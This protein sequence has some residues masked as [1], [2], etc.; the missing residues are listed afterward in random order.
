MNNLAI[1]MITWNG[2]DLIEKALQAVLP[3]VQ[4]AVVCD[5]GSTDNTINILGELK[6]EFPCLN[7]Y[8]NSIQHLGEVWSDSPIDAAI[9]DILNEMKNITKSKWILRVDDDEIFPED[10]MKEIID[11]EPTELAYA[12]SFIHFEG[13]HIIDP[14][15]HKIMLATR[16]FKNIPEIRWNGVFG[17]EALAY[18]GKRYSAKKCKILNNPFLHFGEFRKPERQHTSPNQYRYH[19]PG[20]C[21]LPIPEEYK[22]YVPDHH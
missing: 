3:Y 15:F 11:L 5:T 20:H 10:T 16:L 14:R 18:N 12:F 1:N 19:Q 9:A 4:E 13:D 7:I 2:E 22:K 17:K 6:K 8:Q 21:S